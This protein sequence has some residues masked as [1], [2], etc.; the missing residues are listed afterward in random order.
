M[1]SASRL[2]ARAED[3]SRRL[4]YGYGLNANAAS[5]ARNAS[6]HS[7]ATVVVIAPPIADWTA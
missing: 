5:S 7:A 3:G 6:G 2:G 4:R 1:P